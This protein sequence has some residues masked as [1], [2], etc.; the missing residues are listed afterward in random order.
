MSLNTAAL[1]IPRE[2]R[3]AGSDPAWRAGTDFAFPW[4]LTLVLGD[5]TMF[6]FSACVAFALVFHRW[7]A[8]L[9]HPSRTLSL[10]CSVCLWVLV[11]ARLGLYKRS[12]ALSMR[13]EIYYTVA[14]VVLG[15][16]PQFVV[17]TIAPQFSTSRLVLALSAGLTILCVGGFRALH[18]SQRK[19]RLARRPRRIAVVGRPDRIA[20]SAEKLDLTAGTHLLDLPVDD[21]ESSVAHLRIPRGNESSGV[22]WVDEALDWQCDTLMLTEMLPPHVLPALLEITERR[23]VKLA[24]APPRIFAHAYELTLQRDGRQA[25]IVPRRLKACTPGAKLAKRL[26][27]LA[28]ALAGL[29]F[30]APF[31]ALAALAVYVESG[32]PVLYRQTRVGRYGKTFT[33]YKFR[34]MRVD[35]EARSGPVWSQL[36]DARVTRVGRWLRRLSVDELPQLFNVLRGEMSIVGPRPERPEFVA[37]FRSTIPRYDER[38]LVRPGITGWSQMHMQ[39]VLHTSQA[40]QK[41]G[42]DLFYVEHWSLFMDF[43]LLFKTVFEFLFQ[44][45]A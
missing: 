9:V 13:D 34:S 31:M 33:M 12:F 43:S 5:L 30:A 4:A 1:H 35:A 23:N 38:H 18:Y 29:A 36:G 25:L 42:N 39:R 2:R 24:F 32:A 10:V 11:F 45:A 15:I 44:R 19:V 17:F 37:R 14:A 3:V 6:A 8:A 20:P 28:L 7:D 22:A 16:L 41:L 27:D 40:A 26:C 21:I